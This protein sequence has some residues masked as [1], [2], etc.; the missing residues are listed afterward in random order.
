GGGNGPGEKP[1]AGKDHQDP[2]RVTP[3]NNGPFTRYAAQVDRRKPHILGDRPD[4]AD[5]VEPLAPLGPADRS[6]LG[7]Q[8]GTDRVDLVLAHSSASAY[9]TART[10]KITAPRSSAR[11]CAGAR[12]R[13]GA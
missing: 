7:P 2:R 12:P 5:L 11:F 13:G 4:G 10:E 8:Q 3:R 1:P 9:R 6:G